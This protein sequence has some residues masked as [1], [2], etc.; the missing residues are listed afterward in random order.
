MPGTSRAVQYPT[1]L[2]AAAALQ[3]LLIPRCALQSLSFDTNIIQRILETQCLITAAQVFGPGQL[4]L[5]LGDQGQQALL[6]LPFVLSMAI[7]SFGDM[8]SPSRASRIS[9]HRNNPKLFSSDPSHARPLN[10]K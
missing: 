6:C 7:S 2:Q 10:L 5:F 8:E 3:D 4:G 9:T 1:R